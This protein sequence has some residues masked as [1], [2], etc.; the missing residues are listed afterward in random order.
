MKICIVGPGVVGQAT[1][2][3]F[4]KKG[5]YV[6]FLGGSIDKIERLRR[7]GYQAYKK[8][9]YLNGNYDFD[10]TFLTVSTPALA[11]KVSLADFRPRSIQRQLGTPQ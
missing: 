7:E 4:A 9:H 6:V 1:G 2:K 11:G 10:A 5:H 3:A 8:K